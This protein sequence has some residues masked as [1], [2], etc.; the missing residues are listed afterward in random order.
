MRSIIQSI[1]LVCWLNT[2][3]C[4]TAFC[5]TAPRGVTVTYAYVPK[6]QLSEAVKGKREA[7]AIEAAWRK[8]L[9]AGK[10]ARTL[11]EIPHYSVVVFVGVPAAFALFG[12]LEIPVQ[13]PKRGLVVNVAL[14]PGSHGTYVVDGG[15]LI[16]SHLPPEPKPYE[17]LEVHTE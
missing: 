2:A 15:G 3:L 6:G 13:G 12:R 14:A 16:L 9:G 7:L 11:L 8:E 4:V 1:A 10:G 17:W 5:A